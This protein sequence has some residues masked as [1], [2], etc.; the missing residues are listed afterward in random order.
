MKH[1]SV[2]FRL[3]LSLGAMMCLLFLIGGANILQVRQISKKINL[4]SDSA[5]PAAASSLSIKLAAHE[6]M[7]L[8]NT[9][10]LASRQDILDDLPKVEN[11]LHS[12]L[13]EIPRHSRK[14]AL[15]TPG[16][17][18]RLLKNT[19]GPNRSD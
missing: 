3:W 17:T 5:F 19:I 9:A 8:I 16:N 2:R 15:S 12:L 14:V 4:V 1:L 7:E 10:A 11:K 13:P 6:V 18:N